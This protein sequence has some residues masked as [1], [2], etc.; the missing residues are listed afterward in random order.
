MKEKVKFMS[1]KFLIIL[2][3]EGMSVLG[4]WILKFV[5]SRMIDAASFENY[6]QFSNG[7]L[8][9]VSFLIFFGYSFYNFR[10]IK[11]D[12]NTALTK[13]LREGIPYVVFLIPLFIVGN[14][15]I[16]AVNVPGYIYAPVLTFTIFG[17]NSYISALISLAIYIAIIFLTLC[18]HPKAHND[19]H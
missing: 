13:L 2:I 11:D 10:K 19:I 18:I 16:P 9:V 15:T 3:I 7:I 5:A 17:L 6:D 4:G 12:P 14:I 8:L 1:V